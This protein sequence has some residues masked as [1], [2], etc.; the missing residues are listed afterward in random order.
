VNRWMWPF[1]VVAG[2]GLLVSVLVHCMAV[3]GISSANKGLLGVLG[4]GVFVAWVPAVLVAG[5]L[6]KDV[7]ARQFW[8]AVMRGC[9]QW[10]RTAA[11]AFFVYAIVNFF[12]FML[13]TM[14]KPPL[15]ADDPLS[16]RAI[17]GHIAAFYAVGMA[18]LYSAIQVRRVGEVRMCMN[19][20][21]VGPFAKFCPECGAEVPPE[22]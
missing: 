15:P 2:A 3:L 21:R 22:A 6:A 16:L 17:T 14:G 18:I 10:M 11:A 20:H 19:G 13:Q 7:P 8:P 5:S 12:V 1:V 4:L 9:P